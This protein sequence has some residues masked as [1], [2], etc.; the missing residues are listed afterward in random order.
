MTTTFQQILANAE[1]AA[2]RKRE[3]HT[4]FVSS[5]TFRINDKR[6]SQYSDDNHQSPVDPDACFSDKVQDSRATRSTE[7]EAFKVAGGLSAYVDEP[8]LI[9]APNRYATRRP[10]TCKTHE[11]N[12]WRPLAEFSE[13]KATNGKMYALSWCNACRARYMREQRNGLNNRIP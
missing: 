7:H 12:K 2:Q 1:A 9:E 11:G 5:R 6:T 3:Q 10:C 4:E 8:P 13:R